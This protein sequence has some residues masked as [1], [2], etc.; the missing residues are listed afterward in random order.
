MSDLTAFA[1]RLAEGPGLTGKGEIAQVV[2]A[3]GVGGGSDIAVGDDTAAIPNASGGWDLFACE[4][5]IEGFVAAM[6]WFAG[7]SGVM[8][9]LSDVA[10]M[11][12]RPV[13]VVNALWSDSAAAA[14]PVLQGMAAACAAYGAPMVGGHAN[15]HASGGNLAVAV[16]G[17]AERLLTSFD[18]AP[19]DALVM[20]VDLRGAYH[21]PHPFWDAASQA[22]HDRLRADLALLAEA[23]EAGLAHAAKDISQGGVIGTAAMFCECSQV[24]LVI[25][26]D[27]V[28]GPPL[29][30]EEAEARWLSAFPSFGYLLATP[31]AGADALIRRFTE[32]DIAAARIGAFDDSG[33]LSIA[34]GGETACVRDLIADP[35]I[36]CAPPVPPAPPVETAHA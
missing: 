30:D 29:A 14:D 23:A 13:A 19:G 35:L 4:G 28:P 17:R 33:A 24:G 2:S 7:W 16:L 34:R 12:G 9:N 36:G 26:L 20:A 8:V 5:M 15:L 21:D 10:A 32:R 18:A 1:A 22:P 27:L 31:P 6:P 3:L 11:G 25:D